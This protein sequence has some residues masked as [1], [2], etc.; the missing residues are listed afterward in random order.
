MNENDNR[1]VI[2]HE[3]ELTCYEIGVKFGRCG[4]QILY[5]MPFD[6]ADDI[7][8]P[9]HCKLDPETLIG[10]KDGIKEVY[11]MATEVV[12]KMQSPIK[13]TNEE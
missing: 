13:P 1:E 7:R 5:D 8:I 9:E 6:T 2:N 10:I 12:R 3:K 4:T 11:E